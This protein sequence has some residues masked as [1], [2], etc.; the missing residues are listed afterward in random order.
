M[1]NVVETKEWTCG[2]YIVKQRPRI[3]NP[4]FAVFLVFKEEKLIG[5]QFSVPDVEECRWLEKYNKTGRYHDPVVEEKPELRGNA[6]KK[7]L[8]KKANPA[9]LFRK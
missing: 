9:F 6:L 8:L 7:V 5:K 1:F 3:D 4:S 2:K